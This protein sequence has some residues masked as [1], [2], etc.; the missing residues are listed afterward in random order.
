[1]VRFVFVC[2]LGLEFG[3]E[4]LFD[5]AEMRVLKTGKL[6]ELRRPEGVDVTLFPGGTR[7]A[8]SDQVLVRI[9]KLVVL[10]RQ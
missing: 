10:Q 3:Y 9:D 4:A 8:T 5:V 2:V 1:M 6:F 7:D